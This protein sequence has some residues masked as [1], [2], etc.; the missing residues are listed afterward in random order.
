MSV[1]GQPPARPSEAP[2]WR[3]PRDL[4]RFTTT[5]RAD[6][7]TA[8]LQVFGDANERLVTAL[9]FDDVRAGLTDIGWLDPADDDELARTLRMLSQE[10][11]LLD[12][13]QD[14]AHSY[15][16]AEDYERKNLQYSLTRRGEAA[17]DGLQHALDRLHATGALQSAVLDAIAERLRELARLLAGPDSD[18]RRVFLALTELES[19]LDGLRANTK[20]FNSTLQRLL[21]DEAADAATLAEVKASTVAYLEDYVRHLDVQAHVIAE[22]VGE[23]EA[24]GVSVLHHRA[25]AGAD[26]PQL[27]GLDPA[28]RWL[29]QRAA[30]WDGLQRWFRAA[31]GETPRV[32]ELRAVAQRAIVS[33]LR[34]L[35]RLREV[36]HRAASTAADFRTLA[37]WFASC[38]T[39]EDA[40]R[41]YNAAFGLWPARHAHLA[42]DD[43]T[44]PATTSWTAAPPVPVA[45]TLRSRGRSEHIARTAAI[46]DTAALRRRRQAEAARERAEIEAA[47]RQLATGGRVRLS[48]FGELRHDT[49]TRLLELLGRALSAAPDRAGQH[50]A[51]TADGHLEV[52]L[53]PP[54]DGPPARLATRQG[55]LLAPDYTVQITTLTADAA[56]PEAE[57]AAG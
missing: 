28:P 13:T 42:A 5:D 54:L 45:P 47:W 20:Q 22:A 2:L 9:T 1:E 56:P 31:G 17:F 23:V 53:G 43:E 16:T 50:R 29:D 3:V 6:L 32:Q 39:E 44:A 7:H 12:V 19:H 38:P 51:T 14:H 40:H 24:T 34:V 33:L 4:F 55:T 41:L 52:R 36:R 30:K 48:D 25:L 11:R 26:L 15:A 8:V 37:R 35:E 57:E 18:D 46:R 27:P 49:F 21:R 10:W